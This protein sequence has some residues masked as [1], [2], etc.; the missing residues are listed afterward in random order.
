[1]KKKLKSLGFSGECL[2][3]ALNTK[4]SSVTFTWSIVLFVLFFQSSCQAGVPH[5]ER[6]CMV[7]VYI[8]T[9]TQPFR[10]T[11][12]L[13]TPDRTLEL[14]KKLDEISGL[15]INTAG[16]ELVAVQDEDG[17][18]FWID[19]QKGK[20]SR[21]LSFWK[22]GDYEGIESVGDKVYVIKS[23]G[24]IYEVK[25][26][27]DGEANTE[28]YNDFLNDS[29]D[30]EGLGYDPIKHQLLLACK[31]SAGA[32]ENL[33][34][35]KAIYAFDLEQKKLLKDP[36]FCIRLEQVNE[37][38][39][40]DPM[41]RKLEKLNEFFAPGESEFGFSPSAL[42]VSPTTG[43]LYILSSVGKILMIIDQ[44]GRILH[45]EKLKKSIHP[46]PEGICFDQKGNLFIS[47]EGK[48][49]KGTIHQFNF[50]DE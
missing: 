46:Q 27:D 25:V 43:H 24:T 40:T 39:D 45:I 31:A 41:I 34:L 28:K 4:S 8:D 50:L 11:Y 47:N 18:I 16:T 48:N 33:D 30:V 36:R 22:D 26:G 1:M 21:E 20:V 42:A 29:N 10:L 5:I 7:E 35:T 49:G 6:E 13:K 14:P 19:I 2:G 44:N 32:D 3:Y 9:T 37:Y 12:D 17:K 38:L 23:S 15:G